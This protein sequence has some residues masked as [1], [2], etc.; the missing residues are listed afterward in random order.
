MKKQCNFCGFRQD[1][2]D[3]VL[4]NTTWC[5]VYE[6]EVDNL[7]KGCERWCP[8][9]SVNSDNKLQAALEIRKSIQIQID[10]EKKEKAES[11]RHLGIIEQERLNRESAEKTANRA[12]IVSIIAALFALGSCIAAWI[13]VYVKS[14][15]P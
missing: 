15:L 1:K 13:A 7:Q 2:S 9:D 6:K 11:E 3:F 4:R 14:N 8:S 10:R 12:L 5:L